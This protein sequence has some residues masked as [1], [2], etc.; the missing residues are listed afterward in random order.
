MPLYEP[1]VPS[2]YVQPL[3]ALV[4]ERRP[5]ALASI[6]RDAGIARNQIR[7]S[8]TVTMG[9]FDALLCA[10]TRRLRRSDLGFLLGRRCGR[11][12]HRALSRVLDSCTTLDAILTMIARYWRL[13]S[14][15]TA[16]LPDVG[17]RTL[18]RQPASEGCNLPELGC[19]I[20]QQCARMTQ[21]LARAKEC[22]FIAATLRYRPRVA[23]SAPAD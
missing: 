22:V 6:L 7:P 5:A 8:A 3:I 4:K 11:D 17:E 2:R 21:A 14:P 13:I 15:A 9:Q 16:E 18:S 20:R 23:A 19:D 10:A 1:I 12:S